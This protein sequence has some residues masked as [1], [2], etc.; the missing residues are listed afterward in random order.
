MSLKVLRRNRELKETSMTIRL[1]QDEDKL[2]KSLKEDLNF[3]SFRNLV[4]FGMDIIEKLKEWKKEGQHFYIGKPEQRK[5]N[6]VIFEIFPMPAKA[7][8]SV[9]EDSDS[10]S[11]L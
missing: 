8:I 3:S 7:N 2:I 1:T 10:S 5:Y 9:I 4:M 11:Y 6:E